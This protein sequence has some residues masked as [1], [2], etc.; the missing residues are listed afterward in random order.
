MTGTMQPTAAQA[1]LRSLPAE[2]VKS[3][4]K[5]GKELDPQMLKFDDKEALEEEFA[6]IRRI[7][8]EYPFVAMVRPVLPTCAV[9]S[10]VRWRRQRSCKPRAREGRGRGRPPD[11]RYFMR[12]SSKH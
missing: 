6:V 1:M 8:D 10:G 12:C 3:F 2:L 7:I 9:L 11:V 4:D 5:D